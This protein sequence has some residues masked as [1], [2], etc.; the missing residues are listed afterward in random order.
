MNLLQQTK[1][2][3]NMDNLLKREFHLNQVVLLDELIA[4][5]A[6]KEAILEEL[7]DEPSDCM[8]PCLS[9]PTRTCKSRIGHSRVYKG[10]LGLEYRY[11]EARKDGLSFRGNI[12]VDR[13]TVRS[14]WR[15]TQE[16]AARDADWLFRKYGKVP[17]KGFNFS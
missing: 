2:Q 1:E 9:T 12:R 5:E 3:S 16:E 15:D 8:A 11:I 7:S 4:I 10:P 13:S 6:R 14:G 17:V